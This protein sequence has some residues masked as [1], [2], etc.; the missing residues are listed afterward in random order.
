MDLR[1]QRG[2][3]YELVRE[4]SVKLAALYN[5]TPRG[6]A[7]G[8]DPEAIR[9]LEPLRQLFVEEQAPKASRRELETA[10]HD[11]VPTAIPQRV[12]A[13]ARAIRRAR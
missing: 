10:L 13:A 6:L 11:L 1:E 9:I 7:P 8:Y 2:M 3:D 4:A 5:A 12:K